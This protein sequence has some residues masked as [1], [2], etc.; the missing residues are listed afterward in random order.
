MKPP[1]AVARIDERACI[2]CALCLQACPF[3]AIVGA[4]RFMHT[5]I[6]AECVGCRLC[7]PP[8]PVDCIEM[9]Q[10][11]QARDRRQRLALAGQARRRYRAR[12]QRRSDAGASA[13]LPDRDALVARALARAAARLGRR[14]PS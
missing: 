6:A 3:D 13:A 7:V 2:G 4:P 14:G 9:V 1:P 12:A 5:V 8:C 11:G 10:T